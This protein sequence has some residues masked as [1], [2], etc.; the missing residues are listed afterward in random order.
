MI[1]EMQRRWGNLPRLLRIAGGMLLFWGLFL[2]CACIWGGD[3]FSQGLRVPFASW[4][5]FVLAVGK[6]GPFWLC[7]TV[8]LWM[9]PRWTTGGT[10]H[11]RS[12]V[13]WTC[14]FGA[15]WN[16]GIMCNQSSWTEALRFFIVTTP[17]WMVQ[18]GGF[19]AAGLVW[20]LWGQ[21]AE[22]ERELQ[23]AQL[24][25]LRSQLQPHFLFNTLHAIGVTATRDGASASR[26]TTLLGDLLRHSLRERSS[27]LVP[28]A[29]EVELLQPY[30]QLQQL[31]FADRMR[32]RVDLPA[33]LHDALVPDLLLQPLVEN[34]LQHGIEQRPGAGEVHI[35]ASL[36]GAFLVL[37]VRDDGVPVDATAQEGTGLQATRQR[38]QTLFGD[39]ASLTLTPNP[40]GGTTATIRLP[41]SEVRDAA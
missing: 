20:Q 30:L 17:L 11:W 2:L 37:E 38:L 16:S 3:V 15:V 8:A 25:A 31:R 19:V 27:P 9:A 24:R 6:F 33:E 22:R 29:D 36:A 40:Q 13:A 7:S 10:V 32:V 1:P 28:L 39:R 21:A 4:N 34:A 35:R 12:V 5:F 41:F 26:M 14:V 23:Q 18:A